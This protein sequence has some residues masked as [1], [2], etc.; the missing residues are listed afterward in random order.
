MFESS[1]LR[2]IFGPTKE[3][4]TRKWRRL[5]NEELHDIHSSA[6]I[7]RV[8]KSRMRLSGHVARMGNR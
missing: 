3:E 2:G 1:M 5:H 4:V 7:I 6:N 8:N